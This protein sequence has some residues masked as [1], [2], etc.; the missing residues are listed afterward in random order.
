[1]IGS[2]R[3]LGFVTIGAAE[4]IWI[5]ETRG[6]AR[7]L[8]A[9]PSSTAEGR[10]LASQKRKSSGKLSKEHRLSMVEHP[11]EPY[12]HFTNIFK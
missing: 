10:A 3:S 8:R 7:R 2:G 4:S 12:S 5:F 11:L 1:M 6:R 9:A